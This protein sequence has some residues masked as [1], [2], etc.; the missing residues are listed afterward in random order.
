LGRTPRRAWLAAHTSK[1]AVAELQ[2]IAWRTVGRIVDG[3]ERCKQI[4]LV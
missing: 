1:S 4:E 3:E 2:R